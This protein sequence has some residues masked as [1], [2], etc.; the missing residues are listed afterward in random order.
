MKYAAI[1]IFI[2]LPVLAFG[3]TMSATRDFSMPAEGVDTLVI[4]CGAGSLKLR[5]VSTGDKIKRM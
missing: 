4:N 2:F 5:G 3:G 1:L